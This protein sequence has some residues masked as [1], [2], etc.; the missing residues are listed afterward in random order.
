MLYLKRLSPLFPKLPSLSRSI[1][2]KTSPLLIKK[3]QVIISPSMT[4]SNLATQ[5]DINM[6]TLLYALRDIESNN[7]LDQESFV[8]AETAEILAHEFNCLPTYPQK[9]AKFP[10]RPPVVTI[11]GH[12]DHGKTTLLDSFRNS[13]IC[14]SE[15]GG[16][17]QSIGAFSMKTSS[18][19][20]ITFIDTPG[21]KAFTNMRARGAEIT[22]IV[23]LV[24]CATEGVQPT[25]LE[26]IRHARE[27]DVPVIVALN[28]IDLPNADANRVELQLLDAGVEL[29]KFGGE[30]M[31][32]QISAKK[33]MNLDQLEEAILFKSELM[34]LRADK[35]GFARGTI[36]ESK[37]IEGR[38]SLCS[39][40]VQKGTLK[41]GDN[42]VSGNVYGKIRFILNEF[43]E[44]LKEALP[45][46]AVEVT[47]LNDMP[48]SGND[49]IIV[50]SPAKAKAIA[51]RRKNEKEREEAEKKEK[52]VKIVLPKLSYQERR[53]LRTQKTNMIVERLKDELEQ[54]K[55]GAELN[56]FRDLKK[57]KDKLG[58][59]MSF[60]EN[61]EKIQ[62][63]FSDKEEKSINV[64]LKAQNFGMLEALEDSV[65]ILGREKNVPIRI[66]QSEVGAITSQEIEFA[67]EQK[68]V[69]LCMDLRIPRNVMAKAQ[70]LGVAIKSHKIIYH[71]LADVNNLI[72]DFTEPLY[73]T[74]TLGKAEVKQ[75]FSIS[76]K[77]SKSKL[78]GGIYVIN[79]SIQRRGKFKVIRDGDVVYQD[80][81][82]DSLRKLK[83][84]VK[85]VVQ[86]HEGGIG[87]EDDVILKV[88]DILECYETKRRKNYFN[89]TQSEVEASE[90]Q[91][92]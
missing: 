87:L 46:Q 77:G 66:I 63:M 5:M 40:L 24:V 41:P 34:D 43:G 82:A 11:M 25:T 29:E 51:D 19:G 13:N 16:I 68:G 36:I 71:L 4:L 91:D 1:I 28:K 54:V 35:T 38:G 76:E 31:S 74:E 33:R 80:A 86:G 14:A 26:S 90:V 50:S 88:G 32:I 79:G 75:I 64:F 37:I 7:K 58:K 61:L 8:S 83:E 44:Q 59:G 53:G 57:I 15:Y 84:H 92:K 65:N 42:L 6:N 2:T 52:E 45:S 56:A 89:P 60:E 85:E 9:E 30:V 18:G 23:I 21:H 62:E 12:V 72:L 22:D 67:K 81:E 17:T 27:A 78:V 48:D 47:G 3:K 39:L 20:I 49:L 70:K 69:I 73:V 55:A 10:L